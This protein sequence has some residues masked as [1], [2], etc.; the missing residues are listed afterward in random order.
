MRFN[1][2]RPFSLDYV[3]LLVDANKTRALEERKVNI[4]REIAVIIA[5]RYERYEYVIEGWESNA[6]DEP[7][8][9]I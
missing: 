8:V 7:A 1:A 2:S 4:A 5:E 6:V 9:A 3:K